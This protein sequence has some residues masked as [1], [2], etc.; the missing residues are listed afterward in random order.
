MPDNDWSKFPFP[1]NKHLHFSPLRRIQQPKDS[2]GI[3]HNVLV[4]TEEMSCGVAAAAMLIDLRR[5]SPGGPAAEMRLKQIAGRFPGSM[6]E[7]DKKWKSQGPCSGH[8]GSQVTNIE[9]LL[10]NE[11][12]SISATW[13]RWQERAGTDTLALER[14]RTQPALLLWGWYDAAGVSRNGGHFTVAARVTK[15]GKVV[16]LDPWDGTL[17]EISAGNRYKGSGLLDAAVYTG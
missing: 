6:V 17:S 7:Q 3:S 13:H 2:D 10:L 5:R 15:G 9:K 1:P 14:I 11:G 4:Q 8:Q 12:I 16:I